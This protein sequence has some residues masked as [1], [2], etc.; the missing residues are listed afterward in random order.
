MPVPVHVPVVA[1]SVWPTRAVPETRGRAVLTG[2]PA[3]GGGGGGGGG[4]E[5]G[6]GGGGEADGTVVGSGAGTTGAAGAAGGAPSDGG[7]ATTVS[8]KRSRTFA[9]ASRASTAP[10]PRA[11]GTSRLSAK[12]PW[13]PV[14]NVRVTA[15]MVRV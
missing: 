15:P 14:E 13:R 3:G 7:A 12:R 8:V 5:D 6:G 9:P 1:D 11:C 2:A 4:G 10:V